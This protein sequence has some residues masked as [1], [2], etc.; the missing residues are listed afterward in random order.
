MEAV[1]ALETSGALGSVAVARQGE[2]LARAFL[3]DRR[4]HAAGLVPAAERVVEEAG[5]G[6]AE[7]SAIL[8]GGGPGSFTG[9]RVAA[10]AGKGM[11]HALGIPLLSLSSLMAGAL[12]EWALP[13]GTGP[14]ARGGGREDEGVEGGAGE[15]SPRGGAG[16]GDRARCVLFDARGD[17][18]FAGAYALEGDGVRVLRAPAFGHLGDILADP[19][20]VDLPLCGDAAVRHRETLEGLGRRVLPPP[21][22]VA[23]ADGLLAALWGSPGTVEVDLYDWEPQ[24]L[25]ASNA[26][27]GPGA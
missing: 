4:R 15:P 22:G 8:V 10:A 14:W 13:A 21:A 20:M 5:V 25:R 6:R 2:V 16:P 3:A 19:T 7:L 18:V 17:R 23:T 12:T 26:E 1:L 27:R 24:Y 9:V 11:A